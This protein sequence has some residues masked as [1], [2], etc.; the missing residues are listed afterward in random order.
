LLLS[1]KG[2]REKSPFS[3]IQVRMAFG[4]MMIT[5]GYSNFKTVQEKFQEKRRMTTQKLHWAPLN[6]PNTLQESFMP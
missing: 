3:P 2:R 4:G 5:T 1:L 6:I